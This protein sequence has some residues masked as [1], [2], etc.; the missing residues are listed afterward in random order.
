MIARGRESHLPRLQRRQTALVALTNSA[1]TLI[2]ER[3]MMDETLRQKIEAATSWS[4]EYGGIAYDDARRIDD[5]WYFC[6]L[7]TREFR[8]FRDQ[9]AVIPLFENKPN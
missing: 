9:S 3:G 4:V 2:L 7:L 8:R 1:R 6:D 5:G